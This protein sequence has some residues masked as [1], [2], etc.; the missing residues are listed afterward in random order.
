ME[1]SNAI[2]SLYPIL[3]PFWPNEITSKMH[4]AKNMIFLAWFNRQN[5]NALVIQHKTKP[6]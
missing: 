4:K 3:T 1:E 2:N 6:T 5:S